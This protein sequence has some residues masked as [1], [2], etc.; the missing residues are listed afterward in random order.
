VSSP[1]TEH[2]GALDELLSERDVRRLEPLYC[3]AVDRHDAEL[4]R[5]LFHPD[6]VEQRGGPPARMW[7]V[8]GPMIQT[9]RSL[10][11]STF[12]SV[13]QATV[14]VAGD[15]ATSESYY[16]SV[17]VVDGGRPS[18]SKVFGDR[19][20]DDA[21]RA[22]RVDQAHEIVSAGRYLSRYERR[23]GEWRFAHR[24]VVTEWNRCGPNRSNFTDGLLAN[25]NRSA[26]ESPGIDY[27]RSA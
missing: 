6:G 26:P 25:L 27:G 4:L 3:R 24:C 19:F 16:V 1:P 18:L 14:A 22:G 10:F 11:R 13:T 17:V 20:A 15:R 23:A 2:G 5:S 7:D 21:E 8:A 12:H 9:L